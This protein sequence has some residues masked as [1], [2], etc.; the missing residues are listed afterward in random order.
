MGHQ[1]PPT[2]PTAAT[3]LASIADAGEANCWPASGCRSHRRSAVSPATDAPQYARGTLARRQVRWCGAITIARD[4][5]L[6]NEKHISHSR[7]VDERRR[8]SMVDFGK[9]DEL[10]R[11]PEAQPREVAIA[12]ATAASYIRDCPRW[13]RLPWLPAARRRVHTRA[14]RADVEQSAAQQVIGAEHQRCWK[15]TRR[16]S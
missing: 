16:G 13:Q 3:G 5:R 10:R 6:S 11:W 14:D 9:P 4:K 7:R 15:S 1:E 12:L 2:F 8:E